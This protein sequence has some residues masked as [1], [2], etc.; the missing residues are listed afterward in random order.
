MNKIISFILF[1]FF[2]AF[3]FA[4]TNEGI[5]EIKKGD[6]YVVVV[7]LDGC[8]WDYPYWYDTP[9]FGRMATE[10][11][12]SGLV[13]CFPSKTFPNHYSI[14]TGLT[15]DHHGIIANSFL[16]RSTGTVFSLGNKDTKSLPRFWGGEPIW[17]T[18][19]RNGVRTSVFYW[20]GSDVAI[21]GE[22]PD[23]YHVYDS[24]ERLS[25]KQRLDGM[26]NELK[27]SDSTRP[28]LVMGYSEEPDHSGHTYG[29]HDPRTRVAVEQMDSQLN[30][31]YEK[32]MQL[33]IADKIDFL[34]VSDHGM[35]IITPEQK[36]P[37]SDYLKPEWY[38]SIEGNMPAHIYAAPGKTDSIY[39][40]LK[41]VAHLTVWRGHDTDNA[42]TQ[43]LGYGLNVNCG[44]VIVSPDLG[45]IFYDG[46]VTVGGM[47]G[48]DPGFNAMHAMFRA[49]GPDFKN[50][51]RPHFRNVDVYP[52]ICHLLGISPAENDGNL[53]EIKDILK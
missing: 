50:V 36:I 16:E 23:I 51:S 35:A 29:P 20:P 9:F 46:K 49:V 37:V 32:L 10:G 14:A 19:K 40:A 39:N 24:P 3:G 17:L 38:E 1:F 31:F 34:V 6:R 28:H 13:P 15:P 41:D 43:R 8:R 4:S 22:Y 2:C 21:Q 12:E 42:S 53:D 44:D 26:L 7:S 45:W 11:V 25:F 47:H 30:D 5:K 48:F 33:P 18:A 52:L 27:K